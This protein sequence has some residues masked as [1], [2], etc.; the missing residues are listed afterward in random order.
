VPPKKPLSKMDPAQLCGTWQVMATT[1]PF[2][3][4]RVAPRIEY[5]PLP[6]GRWLDRVHYQTSAGATRTIVGYD[7]LDRE[8]PGAFRWR[9]A[10][11]LFWCRS[12]WC[13]VEADLQAGL[14]LTWFSAATLNVTPAGWDLYARDAGVD[15]AKLARWLA[16][17]EARLG[18]TTD[19]T[20]FLP[21]RGE[22]PERPL[23]P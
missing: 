4:G 12:D 19:T 21:A 2:W 23:R 22:N 7:E 11:W 18:E 3:R 5:Q 20:W 1:L 13:F 16:A 17:V 8:Q 15:A 9:G 6:D 14:A 10:G